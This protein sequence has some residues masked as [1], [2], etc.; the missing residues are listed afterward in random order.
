MLIGRDCTMSNDNQPLS[1]LKEYLTEPPAGKDAKWFKSSV[2]Y[3]CLAC[4]HYG[5]KKRVK[6]NE[7]HHHLNLKQAKVYTGRWKGRK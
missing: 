6:K 4:A 3:T 5:V 2:E 7:I 1:L